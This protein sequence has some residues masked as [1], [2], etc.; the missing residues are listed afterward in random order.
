MWFNSKA[1]AA[2]T[3]Y[4]QSP[5]QTLSSRESFYRFKR[6]LLRQDVRLAHFQLR[7]VLACP[8]RTH[9]YFPT[10]QGI[11]RMNLVS[12]KPD[13]FMSLREFALSGTM[14]STVDADCG[15]LMC[16]T[17]NGDYYIKGLN[18]SDMKTYAEGQIT[19]D[20]SG[21]TNHIKIHKPRRSCGPAA[22]IA[23]NDHG[24]R[25]LDLETQKFVQETMYPFALNCTAVSPDRRLRSVVGDYF[26]VLITNADTGEV[27]QELGGHRDYGF[28]C[29]WSDDGWTVA[30]GFQDMA[31]KIWDA[32]HWCDSN[33]ISTPLRTI[34]TEMAGARNLRFSPV[35]SGP[36]VLV[37][38]EEADIINIID[39][40]TFTHKQEIDMFGEI[41]GVAFVNDGQDL[42]VLCCDSN[43]GGLL[44]LE[45]CTGQTEFKTQ[46]DEESMNSR[47]SWLPDTNSTPAAHE[48]PGPF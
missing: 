29:D 9:A 16:G 19:S 22:A 5:N 30:T 32:R 7:S 41:G 1:E 2:D 46:Y 26:N 15:V 43:R 20:L 14:I 38:A 40:K 25:L 3:L 18:T 11:T 34:R 21:I 42:N 44:Q 17:F 24:F 8:T 4:Q 13:L 37:A 10:S 35:G 45:R 31:V 27:L 28:A 33:G 23:S 6:M 39:A 12:R 36:P 47:H 48:V